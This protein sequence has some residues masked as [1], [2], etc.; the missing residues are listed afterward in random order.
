L[1][2]GHL[3]IKDLYLLQ[4]KLDDYEDKKFITSLNLIDFEQGYMNL[5]LF[6]HLS[7]I[8]KEFNSN[9]LLYDICAEVCFFF[10]RVTHSFY[11]LVSKQSFL[12]S[13][14]NL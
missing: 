13:I 11:V 4:V 5:L 6:S 14:S 7:I 3:V 12:F 2:P 8:F 9:L 10:L 1:I